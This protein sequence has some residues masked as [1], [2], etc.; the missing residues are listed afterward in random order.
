M[1]RTE[2][3]KIGNK[4]VRVLI[5]GGDAF[6]RYEVTATGF[7]PHGRKQVEK[8]ERRCQMIALEDAMR[9]HLSRAEETARVMAIAGTMTTKDTRRYGYREVAFRYVRHAR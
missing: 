3:E 9:K 4:T 7:R 8:D 6:C 2:D 5:Y 1:F